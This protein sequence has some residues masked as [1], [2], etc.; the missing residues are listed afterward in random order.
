MSAPRRKKKSAKGGE[1]GKEKHNKRT[2]ARRGDRKQRG[3]VQLGSGARA[4]RARHRQRSFR[5]RQIH[6][7]FFAVSTGREWVFVFFWSGG[8]GGEKSFLP[9]WWFTSSPEH[10]DRCDGFFLWCV[11]HEGVGEGSWGNDEK[12]MRATPRVVLCGRPTKLEEK[13]LK[14]PDKMKENKR[15]GPGER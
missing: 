8:G 4:R 9:R 15:R 10:D 6:A 12:L 7:L 13:R 2:R 5:R 1:G 14:P 3:A 11:E